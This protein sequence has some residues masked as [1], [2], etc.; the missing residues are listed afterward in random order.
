[1]SDVYMNKKFQCTRAVKDVFTVSSEIEC[2]HRYV[3]RNCN[4]LNYNMERGKKE[5]CEVLTKVGECSVR[6]DQGDWKTAIIEV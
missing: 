4:R 6:S 1:M 5:N 2:S 3:R